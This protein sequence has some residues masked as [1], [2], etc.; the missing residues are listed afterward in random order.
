MSEGTQA[1]FLDACVTCRTV[2]V[3]DELLSFFAC[4]CVATVLVGGMA[5]T[6]KLDLAVRRSLAQSHHGVAT[7]CASASVLTA[8]SALVA[9]LWMLLT[10]LVSG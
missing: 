2:R 7:C 8:G 6:V 9:G 4:I 3:V 10:P 5:A 1:R